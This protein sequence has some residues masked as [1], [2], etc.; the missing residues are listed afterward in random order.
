[1]SSLAEALGYPPGAKLVIITADDL[2][3]SYA[4]NAAVYE[5]LRAG[6]A[7]SAGLVVP[8]PWAREAAASY[9]GEDVGVH[10]TLNA[11]YDLYRW[12]PVTRAP[13]LLDGDGGFP[14]TLVDLWEHADIDEVLKECRAQIERA[15]Y[16]G[17]DVSHLSTHMGAM[18]LRPEFFDVALELA[19]EFRLPLRLAGAE[20]QRRVGF[21][22]RQLAAEAGVVSPDRLLRAPRDRSAR[23]A[24]DQVLADLPPGVTELVLRPARD[25]EELRAISPDWAARVED[26][27]I[28]TAKRDL[29]ALA[30]RSGLEFT[31]YRALRDLQQ[32]RRGGQG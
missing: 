2:G 22:F 15:I 3:L 24:V 20:H 17:F 27:D 25:S 28:A 30:A 14:R 7:T 21:P 23:V 16:W 13:S 8:G 26:Y 10:L 31:S 32:R 5:S 4:A 29:Q 18:E 1:M 12:G 11:E 9:R 6:V 19:S